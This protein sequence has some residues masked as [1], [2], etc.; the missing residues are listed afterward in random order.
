MRMKTEKRREIRIAEFPDDL[1]FY[2]SL[3]STVLQNYVL[4]EHLL[5]ALVHNLSVVENAAIA[6]PSL[7][8]L[9]Q[10]RFFA[11]LAAVVVGP[12]LHAYNVDDLLALKTRWTGTPL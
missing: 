10:L 3:V 8:Q 9:T 1:E 5:C 4:G 2:R 6:N 12:A 11:K 7:G